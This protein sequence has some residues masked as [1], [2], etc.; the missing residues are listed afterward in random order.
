MVAIMERRTVYLIVLSVIALQSSTASV[1]ANDDTVNTDPYMAYMACEGTYGFGSC[2]AYAR[3]AGAE[4]Y[5]AQNEHSRI[6]EHRNYGDG[7]LLVEPASKIRDAKWIRTYTVIVT[8]KNGGGSGQSHFGW[9]HRADVIINTDF[10][11]VVGCWPLKSAVT[12]EEPFEEVSIGVGFNTSG[13][14]GDPY[15]DERVRKDY[16][17]QHTYYA[18]GVFFI[19]HERYVNRTYGVNGTIDYSTRTAKYSGSIA[20][21]ELEWFSPDDLKECKQIPIVADI[22]APT[23]KEFAPNRN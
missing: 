1:S 13:L 19:R 23:P 7:I 15:P 22:P 10:R 11:Q 21:K 16:G 5:T 20:F 9:V 4:I 8:K 14:A 12:P 17:L 3:H 2:V 18:D 6:L